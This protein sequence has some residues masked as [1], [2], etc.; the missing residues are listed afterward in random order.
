ML[1]LS[2]DKLRAARDR[3]EKLKLKYEQQ[4]VA[5]EAQTEAEPRDQEYQ[6]GLAILNGEP[7]QEGLIGEAAIRISPEDES[8]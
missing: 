7:L 3:V 2:K 5:R 6:K 8:N 4:A 1:S